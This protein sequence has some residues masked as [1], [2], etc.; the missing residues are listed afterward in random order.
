MKAAYGTRVL[1]FVALLVLLASTAARASA[2]FLV[3]AEWL[4]QHIHDPKLVVLEVR[5]HPHRYFTIGH[6]P[7]AVQ[8]QRFKDLGD[9]FGHPTMRFPA[10]DAFQATLRAWGVNNDSTPRNLRRLDDGPRFAP[11]FSARSLRLRHA[12][13]EDSE[14]RNHRLDGVQ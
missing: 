1:M 13:G 9:N 5:Y 6:I 11:V 2:D 3:N 8:V 10:R 4:E 14:R 12:A 7:G